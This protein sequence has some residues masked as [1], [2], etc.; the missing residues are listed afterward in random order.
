MKESKNVNEP[1]PKIV[2]TPEWEQRYQYVQKK[3]DL[4]RS[5]GLD[6]LKILLGTAITLAAVPIAFHEKVIVLFPGKSVSGMYL[7]WACILLS[8]FLGFL[9]YLF[10]FEGYYHQAH[11]EGERWLLGTQD[12]IKAFA[13]RSNRM[14]DIA[15]RFDC[16]GNARRTVEASRKIKRKITARTNIHLTLI[17]NPSGFAVMTFWYCA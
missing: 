12:K 10:I 17:K 3:Y 14:F 11:L 15:H 7:S 9:S 2:W 6:I 4:A 1:E 5:I 8:V 13:Q 16:A